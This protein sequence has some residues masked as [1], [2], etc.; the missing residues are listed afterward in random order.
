M[1][2]WI[3]LKAGTR[4]AEILHDLGR[5]EKSELYPS[6]YAE[7]CDDE[8]HEA[9]GLRGTTRVGGS[10]E[11]TLELILLQIER[12]PGEDLAPLLTRAQPWLP[13]SIENSRSYGSSESSAKEESDDS[14]TNAVG[15]D[16]AEDE[17]RVEDGVACRRM[18]H[19][20]PPNRPLLVRLFRIY[21]R[22]QEY[23]YALHLSQPT[24]I[25]K[26]QSTGPSSGKRKLS[27]F[28]EDGELG[29]IW[30]RVMW[31]IS[32]IIGM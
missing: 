21:N 14:E 20:D 31:G 3:R 4:R 10:V 24:K 7:E 29:A 28:R 30:R 15:A 18:N 2:L 11:E 22:Y 27:R 32:E 6:A 1:G 17:P 16:D 26:G 8:G 19:P 25:V 9:G 23:R 12:I 5:L 13:R